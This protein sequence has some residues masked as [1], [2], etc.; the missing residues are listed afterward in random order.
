MSYCEHADQS[1]TIRTHS[2]FLLLQSLGQTASVVR[3]KRRGL[4]SEDTMSYS[5]DI[6]DKHDN[7]HWFVSTWSIQDVVLW[8]SLAYTKLPGLKTYHQPGQR[9]LMPSL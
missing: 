2:A 4:W 7:I 8:L 5:I 6:F 3:Q 1:L 9:D